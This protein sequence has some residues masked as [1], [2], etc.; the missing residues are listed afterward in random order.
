MS[1]KYASYEKMRKSVEDSVVQMSYR[2]SLRK[3]S[4]EALWS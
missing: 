1:Q 2:Q 3:R 4:A